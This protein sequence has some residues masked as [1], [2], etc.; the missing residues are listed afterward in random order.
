MAT[1]V[2]KNKYELYP[3]GKFK[4]I[5]RKTIVGDLDCQ[6]IILG[7]KCADL[8]KYDAYDILMGNKNLGLE[9]QVKDRLA[10]LSTQLTAKTYVMVD[11]IIS[12]MDSKYI[13]TI[14]IYIEVY[15]HLSFIDLSV[16]ENDKFVQKGYLGNRVDIL[17][18]MIC[19]LLTSK[20]MGIGE[21]RIKS[22]RPM[23]YIQPTPDYYGKTIILTVPEF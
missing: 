7:E 1:N 22:L 15:S 11:T 23:S 16:D 5:I 6:D 20:T 2:S 8:E 4:D 9:G 3:L 17:L 10:M 12:N 13:K 18:D 19:R 14:D 21:T